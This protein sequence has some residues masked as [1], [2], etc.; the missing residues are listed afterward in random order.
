[1]NNDSLT[2]EQRLKDMVAD[3]ITL[4]NPF[5]LGYDGASPPSTLTGVGSEDPS[6]V[7]ERK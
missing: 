4:T 6:G 3:G 7:S 2:L 5:A 1:M